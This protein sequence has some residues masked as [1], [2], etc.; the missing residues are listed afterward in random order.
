MQRLRSDNG[1]EYLAQEFTGYLKEHKI[2]HQLSC[3]STPQQNGVSERKN[4]HLADISGSMIHDK[5]IPGRFWAEAMKTAS[6]VIN[7]IP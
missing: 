3:P 2:R 5:N 6:Y 4:R 1:G 7:R